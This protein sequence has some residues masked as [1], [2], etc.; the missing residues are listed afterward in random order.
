MR[1]RN[2][3]A[4]FGW[5][6]LA[7]HWAMALGLLGA[8]GLGT[9]IAGMEPSVST[10]WLYGLHK[11]IGI[12]LLALV[13]AR[14]AWHRISPPPAS[15]TDGIAAWQSI[16]ARWAHR[17]L[18]LLMLLVPLSGW[19]GS[20]ATGIDVVIFGQLALPRIAPVS[21]A[22]DSAAFAAHFWLTRALMALIG[23]HVAGA[24]W[25]HFGHRDATLRRM[26]G[27]A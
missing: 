27:R 7:L 1:A 19:M 9:Y 13:L 12:S 25:R 22:W 14:L 24:L 6:S 11:T 10:L 4:R 16:A 15:Y 20:A 8:L 3:T 26:L 5:V 18:Y 2:D 17:G 21:E 23:L